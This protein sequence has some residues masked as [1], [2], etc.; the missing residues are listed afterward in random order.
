M[1]LYDYRQSVD[2]LSQIGISCDKIYLYAHCKFIQHNSRTNAASV[3]PDMS[4]GSV[5][6]RPF[7]SICI[8]LDFTGSG[9][10]IGTIC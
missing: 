7:F 4:D 2:R 3:S 6:F 8:L 5:I 9:A 10:L 1:S